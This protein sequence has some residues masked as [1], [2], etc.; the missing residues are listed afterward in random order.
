MADSDKLPTQMKAWLY[1][2]TAGGIE[3]NL[4]LSTSARVPPT[5]RQDQLLVQ[6]ISVSINPADIKVPEGP[7]TRVIISKPASPCMDFCGKVITV[8]PN[9][10]EFEPGQLVYGSLGLPTQF[11]TLGEYIIAPTSGT[12]LLPGGVDPDHAATLGVAG[13]T[14]YQALEPYVSA[15]D[16]VFINGGSGGCGIFAIQIAKLLGCH[17]T[18]SCSTKNVQF[19]K[20]LGA[21]EVLDYTAVDVTATLKDKGQVFSHVIDHIGIPLNLYS[22]CHHFLLPGKSFVQV[23]AASM[24]TYVNRVAR[25]RLLGGGRRKFDILL[26]RNKK[27][28]LV[29]VGEWMHEGKIKAALDSTFEFE[30]AVKAFEKLRT[31][32]ARGKIVIHVTP[33][34]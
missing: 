25:P 12:A 32:H 27:D 31:G 29:R 30:D 34:P 5:V 15:G 13:Q 19:C 8:G 16:K 17:V 7:I 33:K 1:S 14:A 10:T 26:W 24:L 22:E 11:G 18:T 20:D 6:V 3:K 28:G 9:V 23:G 21:D 2:S 4:S